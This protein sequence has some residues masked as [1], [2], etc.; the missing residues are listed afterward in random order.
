MS[1][2]IIK[3]GYEIAALYVCDINKKYK[4]GDIW[5]NNKYFNTTINPFETMFIK[6][7]EFLHLLLNCI[8][9]YYKLII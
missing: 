6:K 7:I 4:T 1:R 2:A 3:H 8:I 9:V 5:Y